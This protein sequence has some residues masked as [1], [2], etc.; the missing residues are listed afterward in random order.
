ML[1]AVVKLGSGPQGPFYQT[2]GSLGLIK[3]WNIFRR[4]RILDDLRVTLAELNIPAESL[5]L[6]SGKSANATL[7]CNAHRARRR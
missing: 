2:I 6:Y 3:N 5:Q 7:V 4:E 1:Q